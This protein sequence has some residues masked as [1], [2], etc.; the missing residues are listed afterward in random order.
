[1]VKTE[2]YLIGEPICTAQFID[3]IIRLQGDTKGK[4]YPFNKNGTGNQGYLFNLKKNLA[5]FFLQEM[6]KRDPSMAEK[7][8]VK[9][10]LD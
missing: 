10:M 1:M 3:E 4:G 7:S 2:Y 8:Y 9:A 6:I 5:K